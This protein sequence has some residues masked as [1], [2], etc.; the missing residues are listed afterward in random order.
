ML[1]KRAGSN[2]ELQGRPSGDATGDAA[3]ACGRFDVVL[4][5]DGT[6]LRKEAGM[7]L[8]PLSP[9]AISS[10]CVTRPDLA[11]QRPSL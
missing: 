4:S 5:T 6:S 3:V 8:H 10:L 11:S 7:G 9:S 2:P 1:I